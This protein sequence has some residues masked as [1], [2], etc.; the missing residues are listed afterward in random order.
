MIF[1]TEF[2][3]AWIPFNAW[4]SKN[5]DLKTEREIINEIKNNNSMKTKIKY[6][7]ENTDEESSNF[8]NHLAMF[9]NILEEL[10][11]K[12]KGCYV[13]FTNIIIERNKKTLEEFKKYG[14]SYK[15]QYDTDQ[16]S[17]KYK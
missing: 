15:A 3:K 4:M 1:F 14:Y 7:L 11:L 13:N 10:E 17:V 8:R 16:D 6:F 12:N 5:Y 9:H 2:V